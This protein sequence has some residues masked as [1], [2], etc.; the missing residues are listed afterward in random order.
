MSVPAGKCL[1]QCC[2]RQKDQVRGQRPDP[3]RAQREVQA[4][5]LPA[6]LSA[7]PDQDCSPCC[8]SHEPPC[9]HVSVVPFAT[10]AVPG[11]C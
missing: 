6:A 5:C 3:V 11:S 1:L 8:P 2:H 4:Q 7:S 10:A 9:S